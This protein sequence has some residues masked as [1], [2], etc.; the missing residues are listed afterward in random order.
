MAL[1]FP[2]SP[3][4]GNTFVSDNVTYTYNESKGVWYTSSVLYTT[5][6]VNLSSVGQNVIPSTNE[7]YNLGSADYKWKDLYLS[8]NTINL[9]GAQLKTNPT[10]G[11]IA[12]VPA[13]TEENPNPKAT[14]VSPAGTISAVDTSGG[15]IDDQDVA[16]ASVAS[17]FLLPTGNVAQRS[18]NTSNGS[19]R[20]NSEY[21]TLEL[22][23]NGY[24]SNIKY[25]GGIIATGGNYTSFSGGYKVHV[26]TSSGTFS[27]SDAPTNATI[28]YLVVAGGGAGGGRHAG[29]G[30]AGG[31]ITG[32]NYAINVGNYT[33][34]VGAG[35][36]TAT[37]GIV[38]PNGSNSSLAPI[39]T[40]TGGG[41]G[42]VYP[43]ATGQNGGSGGGAGSTTGTTPGGTGV[44]GQ[45]FAGGNSVYQPSGDIR[46]SGGGGGASE[47]GT[48]GNGTNGTPGRGGNGISV[49]FETTSYY[50]AGGGGGGIW[51][52]GTQAGNGGAGGG[53]GGGKQGPGPGTYGLGDT[54]GRNPG[55]NGVWSGDT[56]NTSSGGA[57]GANTGGGGGG[58]GQSQYLSFVGDGGA[59]GSGIVI[60]RYRSE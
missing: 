10:S 4:D 41:G 1:D 7:T 51:N 12:I 48:T 46:I 50:Y 3:A 55:E 58:N 21:N 11:A 18:E 44:S 36:A 60:V 31:F 32:S 57:G 42:G 35:G 53:G 6:D 38:G 54:Q 37:G 28:D 15:E 39:A 40:A 56:P 13:A 19:I 24:W 25:L 45:G 27:V 29:G 9:G 16:N 43:L 49:S 2:S 22:F 34:T 23:Y 33:V 8:G 5:P 26:F 30:G 59:G 20:I 17:A 14:V 47:A 52:G